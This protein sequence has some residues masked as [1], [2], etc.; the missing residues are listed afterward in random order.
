[1]KTP[2]LLILWSVVTLLA[3]TDQNEALRKAFVAKLNETIQGNG[4]STHVS[5]ESGRLTLIN[6]IFKVKANRID[7]MRELFPPSVR[8]DLC[9]I[10]FK[11]V[12][13]KD[14]YIVYD[15]TVVSLGCPETKEETTARVKLDTKAMAD[16][17]ASLQGDFSAAVPGIRLTVSGTTLVITGGG[18]SN[19]GRMI[20]SDA[21]TKRSLCNI[22]FRGTR[23][24]GVY[25]SLGCR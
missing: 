17:A 19:L 12:S 14:G 8:R 11:T 20:A 5:E 16:Y 18:N 6:E 23:T 13:F 25:V 21:D 10:G 7:T 22:G 24:G 1:M 2:A 3:A 15:E 9:K 4:S